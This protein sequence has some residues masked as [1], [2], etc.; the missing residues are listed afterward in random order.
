MKYLINVA[1]LAAMALSAGTVANA[2][3][4]GPP[5]VTHPGCQTFKSNGYAFN[6]Y[7]AALNTTLSFNSISTITGNIYGQ[8]WISGLPET[9]VLN[10]NTD[11]HNGGYAGGSFGTTG[12]WN[13]SF[14]YSG[15]AVIANGKDLIDIRFGSQD[16]ISPGKANSPKGTQPLYI[17]QRN[18]DMAKKNDGMTLA[19]FD[20]KICG[21]LPGPQDQ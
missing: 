6:A 19:G 9:R 7:P 21:I 18:R 15:G 14:H 17:V 4:V 1:V 8:N 13:S 11:W 2:Q 5:N 20:L 10:A 3:I 16:G 12:G